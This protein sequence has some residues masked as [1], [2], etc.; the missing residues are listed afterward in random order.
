[1]K[2]RT[3]IRAAAAAMMSAAVLLTACGSGGGAQQTQVSGAEESKTAADKTEAAKGSGE[4]VEL[5]IS[6]WGSDAR[7]EATLQVLDLFM[8]KYPNIKVSAEYQGFDGYHDKLVTQ[9]SSGTEP[10]PEA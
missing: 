3:G 5:R 6:W 9:I 7:H 8:E 10:I 1:M 2:K 4:T